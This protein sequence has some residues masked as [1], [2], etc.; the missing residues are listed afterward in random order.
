MG[1]GFPEKLGE[2][3]GGSPMTLM[4]FMCGMATDLPK[5]GERIKR[6]ASEGPRELNR[7]PKSNDSNRVTPVTLNPR[8]LA[9]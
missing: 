3:H 8:K 7:R 4:S 2:P 5:V 6:A 1:E 9:T